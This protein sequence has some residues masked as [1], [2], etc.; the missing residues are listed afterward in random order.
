MTKDSKK[1]AGQ[2]KSSVKVNSE[3]DCIVT[4]DSTKPAN[5]DFRAAIID[6]IAN[7]DTVIQSIIDTVSDVI[8]K[9]LLSNGSFVDKLA[10]QLVSKGV[11]D[12]SSCMENVRQQVY[13][14]CKMDF[15]KSVETTAALH[16]QITNTQLSNQ[17]L[18]D[19]LDELE[20]YSRRNCLVFHGLPESTGSAGV[21]NS[22]GA[23]MQVVGSLGVQLDPDCIDRCHRMGRTSSESAGTP[24][25][26]RPVI[27]KFT[28]YEP[29]RA[30]FTAKRKLK[31]TKFVITENLTRRRMEL[32]RKARASA[33]V[34]ASWTSDGRIVCLLSTGRKVT[35]TNGSHL[36][37]LI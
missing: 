10:D 27:V 30:I 11:L 8:V 25:N 21:D 1:K 28:S 26:P 15:D 3:S 13:E 5:G 9:K 37:G 36:K 34:E 31:G 2:A 33:K 29:R 35:V 24:R 18:T 7:D 32:L 16:T 17:S 20:Q 19:E 12:N 14:S 23:I 22:T 4:V 6:I